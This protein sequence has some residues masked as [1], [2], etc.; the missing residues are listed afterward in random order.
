M[1]TEHRGPLWEPG[2]KPRAPIFFKGLMMSLETS[3]ESPASETVTE[4]VSPESATVETNSG[5][6]YST[7]DPGYDAGD[8]FETETKETPSET[9]DDASGEE[10]TEET[11][12]TPAVD[13]AAE[14]EAI[15]DEL[16]DKAFELGYTI[17]D[18]KKFDDVKSLEK[19]ITR[20]A[21]LKE[22]WDHHQARSNS[23]AAPAKK[24]EDILVDEE[25]PEPNWEEL[26]ELG[27]DP[28]IVALN[29]QSWHEAKEAKAMVRQLLQSERQRTFEAQCDRFDDALN[30]IGD[31]FKDVFGTG[32][33]GELIEKSPEQAK[34]RQAVFT[35][36]NMLRHGYLTA[37]QK[38]PPEA[39]LI[40]EA[41]HASFYKHA[42]TTARNRL[43]NDIKRS[44]SQALSRPNSGGEKPLS[45][46]P[47]ALQLEQE[48]W[49]QNNL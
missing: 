30:N 11:V 8:D 18:L 12:E 45:G 38:V 42:Q 34:N 35:K 2:L 20:T 25:K 5:T 19:E 24:P 48:F 39:E 43:K 32:K 4:T 47:K 15:S 1:S 17:D 14:S 10:T 22:R 41:V 3:T 16:L 27:H 31:E 13:E 26:V 7:T 21:Q 37:G 9:S 33:R 28:D 6:G 44:G 46:P 40:Q 36:M 29:K 49:K 23:V